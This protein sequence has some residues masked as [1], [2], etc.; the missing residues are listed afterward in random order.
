MN[1]VDSN[2][3]KKIYDKQTLQLPR[4]NRFNKEVS[5]ILPNTKIETLI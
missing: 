3:S 1:C 4:D 2:C 5:E